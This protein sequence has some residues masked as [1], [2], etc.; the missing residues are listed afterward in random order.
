MLQH[1]TEHG[2]QDDEQ[3]GSEMLPL[4]DVIAIGGHKF[5]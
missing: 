3:G 2:Q 1:N 5:R 4:V